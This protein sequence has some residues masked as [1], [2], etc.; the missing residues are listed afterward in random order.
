M[1]L[2]ENLSKI[3]VSPYKDDSKDGFKIGS[4]SKSKSSINAVLNYPENT[5][6]E[7]NFVEPCIKMVVFSTTKGLS[8]GNW[9][10]GITFSNIDEGTVPVQNEWNHLNHLNIAI[11]NRLMK[12]RL[13]EM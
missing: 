12:P 8:C 3:T 9:R 11:G 10:T 4:I 13:I 6:I 7:I 1:L 5:D 2:S